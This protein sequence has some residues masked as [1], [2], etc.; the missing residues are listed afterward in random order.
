M[1]HHDGTNMSLKSCQSS[2]DDEAG[3]FHP[4]QPTTPRAT[5][6]LE[7]A[8]KENQRSVGFIEVGAGEE[9]RDILVPG[10]VHEPFTR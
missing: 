4:I 9:H 8:K 10:S 7:P 1:R 3:D 5:L 2:D 6:V